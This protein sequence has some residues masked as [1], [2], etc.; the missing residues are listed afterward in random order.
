MTDIIVKAISSEPLSSPF[1]NREQGWDGRA[2]KPVFD[3]STLLETIQLNPYHQRAV[4]LK[5]M[6]SVGLGYEVYKGG[7]VDAGA[8]AEWE[9]LWPN[10]FQAEA[11][12]IAQDFEVFG[13][14]YIEAVKRSGSVIALYHV[15]AVTMRIT[16]TGFIQEAEAGQYMDFEAAGAA[17]DRGIIHLKQYSPAASVYGVPDW[18]GCLNSILLDVY[19]TEW[20]YRFFENNCMPAWAIVVKDGTLTEAAE[21]SI[22]DFFSQRYKGAINAH[23][24]L[25][26]SANNS[27]VLFQQLQ[28]GTK[29]MSFERLKEI[30][31]NE[32]I[33]A[34]GIPPRLL[35]IMSSGQLGGGGEMQWQLRGFKEG[36]LLQRKTFY[37]SALSAYMPG[38]SSMVFKDMDITDTKDDA[39][40]YQAMVGSGVLTPNE[41]RSELGYAPKEGLDS[42]ML[43]RILGAG[44]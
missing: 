29:D 41:A 12:R 19:A 3:F 28:T 7:A 36:L 9:A 38:G 14:A 1:A 35:G 42:A 5:V 22:R 37:A 39:E 30:C 27:E 13:N 2:Y 17:G 23:K 34:H 43:A 26:M 21:Q 31:R 10:G 15:P 4:Q 8:K 6:L 18:I 20:N 25:L 44:G 40:F 32:I 24:T 11:L 33:A 16:R